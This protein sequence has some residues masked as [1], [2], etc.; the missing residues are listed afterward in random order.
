[1]FNEYTLDQ[2]QISYLEHTCSF[3]SRSWTL[4]T[5]VGTALIIIYFMV[6]NNKDVL[7]FQFFGL[8]CYFLNAFFMFSHGLKKVYLCMWVSFVPVRGRGER[9]HKY[10]QQ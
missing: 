10:S 5:Q 9:T 4:S 7:W 2:V 6:N 1:M 3:R 8:N